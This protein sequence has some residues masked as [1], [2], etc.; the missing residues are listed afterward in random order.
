M[1]DFLED[2][3]FFLGDDKR[4]KSK[5]EFIRRE[6]QDSEESGGAGG[7]EGQE[8]ILGLWG[9]QKTQEYLNSILNIN[10]SNSNNNSIQFNKP[11]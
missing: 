9:G 6:R 2:E 4:F 5:T 11:A 3:T 10:N 7:G 8:E 1:L